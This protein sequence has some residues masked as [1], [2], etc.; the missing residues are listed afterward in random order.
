MACRRGM[1]FGVGGRERRRR[2][3]AEKGCC[4]LQGREMVDGSVN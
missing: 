1:R 3:D 4:G 2:R